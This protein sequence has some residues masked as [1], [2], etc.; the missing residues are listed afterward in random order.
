MR[1]RHEL[2]ERARMIPH[3]AM[4]ASFRPFRRLLAEV[5]DLALA[6]RAP[7]QPGPSWILDVGCGTGTVALHLARAGCAVVGLDPAPLLVEAAE[8]R[9][10]RRG[11]ARVAFLP[12]DVAHDPVPG[13]GGYDAVVSLCSRAWPDDPGRFLAGC[14]RT[15]RPGGFGL[16]LARDRHTSVARAFG[17][18]R[19]SAGL[20]HALAGLGWLVPAALLGAVAADG[21]PSVS[22]ERLRRD[23][24]GAGFE[25]IAARRIFAPE[26]G[27]LAWAQV[28]T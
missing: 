3:G 21:R 8:R 27:L 11:A 10:R 20:V 12:L 28:A 26:V 25:V 7:G 17:E 13:A 1:S 14:R 24:A 9:R 6:A 5:A 4:V 22:E 15:L 19:R 23:L 16:F 2:V 18:L